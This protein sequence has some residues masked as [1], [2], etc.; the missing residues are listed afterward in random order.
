VVVRTDG[1]TESSAAPP[2]AVLEYS[3]WHPGDRRWNHGYGES[4][5]AVIAD[6]QDEH[7]RLLQRQDLNGPYATELVFETSYESF[8]GPSAKDVMHEHG[9]DVGGEGG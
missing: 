3:Y 2:G 5:D 9:F 6:L 1:I 4:V 7:W 8:F